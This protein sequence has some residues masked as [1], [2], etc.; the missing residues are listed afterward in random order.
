MQRAIADYGDRLIATEGRTL[1][2]QTLKRLMGASMPPMVQLGAAKAMFSAAGIAT[3]PQDKQADKP[4]NEMTEAELRQFIA[5]M[6]KIVAEGGEAP[7][8]TVIP[9]DSAPE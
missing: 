7:V 3:A 5:K 2:Y 1:A 9:D 4:L 6:D 8:I